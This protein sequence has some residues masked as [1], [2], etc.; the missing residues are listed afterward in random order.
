M[1]RKSILIKASQK[2]A[3]TESWEFPYRLLF[4]HELGKLSMVRL[5]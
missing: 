3:L 2:S 4:L 5:W 1:K